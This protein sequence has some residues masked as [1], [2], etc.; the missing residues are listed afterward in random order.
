MQTV[1]SMM[2]SVI[3]GVR[4]YQNPAVADLL[5]G[6]MNEMMP[7]HQALQGYLV[8]LVGVK[9]TELRIADEEAQRCR[10][11]LIRAK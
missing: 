5:Q 2:Q 8:Q 7:Y 3:A 4:R 6:A 1:D 9:E 11:E 10:S